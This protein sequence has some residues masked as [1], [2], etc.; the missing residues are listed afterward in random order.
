MVLSILPKV[1]PKQ[2][3]YQGDVMYTHNDIKKDGDKTSFTPNTITYTA[4]GDKAKAINKSKMGV[5]FIPNT[6]ELTQAT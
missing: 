1:A 2:G 3:V 4:K 5:V 6:K